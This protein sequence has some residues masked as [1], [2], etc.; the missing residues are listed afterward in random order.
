[1][2]GN[3]R[4][5]SSLDSD[6][7]A[8]VP[9]HL[10]F[11]RKMKPHPWLRVFL[12]VIGLS[13]GVALVIDKQS[14]ETALWLLSLLLLVVVLPIVVLVLA[15]ARKWKTLLHLVL[16]PA[17]LGFLGFHVF[18]WIYWPSNIRVGFGSPPGSSGSY[19]VAQFHHRVGTEWIEGPS[20]EG[21]P[22]RVSFPDLDSDGYK[23]IRVIEENGHRGH[24]IEFVFIPEGK[25]GVF[26]EPHRMDSRLSA[27]YKPSHFFHNYP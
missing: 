23:D 8:A 2:R 27:A 11:A 12:A 20:V 22:M 1:M 3:R 14:S 19:H 25:D 13:L 4:S 9:P 21:W 15:I 6:S 17:L 26:W 10:T 7:C 18:N 24:A 5:A 16:W